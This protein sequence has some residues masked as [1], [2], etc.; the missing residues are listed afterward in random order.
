LDWP[1]NPFW[2][3]ALALYRQD[4]VERAC[5][6]LQ[7]RHGLDVNIVLLCCWLASRGIEAEREWL[8]AAIAAVGP[9]HRQVVRPL[10]AMRRR[11]K[12]ELAGACAGSVPSRWPELTAGLRQ[13]VLALEID[14]ERLEQLLLADRAAGLRATAA[15]GAD[16]AFRNLR[17]Y[18]RFTREDRPALQ[19]LLGAAFP[20]GGGVAGA[21]ERLVRRAGR[22]LPHA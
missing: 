18:R 3:Y 6:D 20:Q 9:W 19:A 17:R 8:K 10:R 22:A 11:L 14:G 16:L 5:L 13:R 4:G 1:A 21:L 12:A 15:P 2:D 7:E